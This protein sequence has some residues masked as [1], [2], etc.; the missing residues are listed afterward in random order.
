MRSLAI[1]ALAVAAC[2]PASSH[3]SANPPP[4]LSS[5]AEPVASV[6]PV[7]SASRPDPGSTTPEAPVLLGRATILA[8]AEDVKATLLHD[9]MLHLATESGL[10]R[11]DKPGAAPT[12]L[13]ERG[14]RCPAIAAG[15]RGLVA[16]LTQQ[17]KDGKRRY[18]VALVPKSGPLKTLATGNDDVLALIVAADGRVVLME[19]SGH[20]LL[21]AADGTSGTKPRQLGEFRNGVHGMAIDKDQVYWLESFLP[22]KLSSLRLSDGKT[23]ELFGAHRTMLSDSS[24]HGLK[25]HRGRLYWCPEMIGSVRGS[26]MSLKTDGTDLQLH[27]TTADKPIGAAESFLSK[28]ASIADYWI[29]DD[30][31]DIAIGSGYI[32]PMKECGPH[33]CLIAVRKEGWKPL[34]PTPGHWFG[35]S[36]M[37]GKQLWGW[38][39]EEKEDKAYIWRVDYR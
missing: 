32:H 22:T 13:S 31:F 25:L 37:T 24:A 38:Y 6:A 18:R 14:W 26:L 35:G 29:R 19:G 30:G 3:S 17:S 39:R 8:E 1:A 10:L 9:G 4:E 33:G 23:N 5:H 15:P 7:A 11:I 20:I 34:R 16:V 21:L 28:S 2:S 27:F 12:R 36:L